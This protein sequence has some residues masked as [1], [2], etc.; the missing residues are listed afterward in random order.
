MDFPVLG[1]DNL[2]GRSMRQWMMQCQQR[3]FCTILLS[4]SVGS[5]CIS[6]LLHG[7]PH[8]RPSTF[9]S[10]YFLTFYVNI[11]G[12]WVIE[13]LKAGLH[14]GPVSTSMLNYS[15]KHLEMLISLSSLL[16]FGRNKRRKGTHTVLLL[17]LPSEMEVFKP[18][19]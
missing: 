11:S 12:Y 8:Y 18:R 13:S 15:E 5:V 4:V 19:L 7:L 2:S 3:L 1:C 16:T 14:P 17:M 10:F 9:P 6:L